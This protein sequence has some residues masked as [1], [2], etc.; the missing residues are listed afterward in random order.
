METVLIL[1][2]RDFLT[3]YILHHNKKLL[4]QPGYQGINVAGEALR[5]HFNSTVPEV[6]DPAGNEKFTGEAAGGAAESYFLHIAG[7]YVMKPVF[8]H[9]Y[10]RTLQKG[11]APQR[12]RSLKALFLQFIEKT[13]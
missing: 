2:Y 7:K 1:N 6:L 4:S 11:S 10:L 5:L 9:R 8:I 13:A 3:L 12:K